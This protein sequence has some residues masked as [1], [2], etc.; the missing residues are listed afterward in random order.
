M[1]SVA[2]T[3]RGFPR[4]IMDGGARPF[5][6]TREQG[7]GL[8]LPIARGIVERHGGTFALENPPEGGARVILT[9]PR[10]DSA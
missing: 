2:D 7:T 1:L 5:M 4:E 6:T 10:S 9:F 3:G 8:G